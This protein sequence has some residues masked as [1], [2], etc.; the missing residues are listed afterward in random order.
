[1]YADWQTL[2]SSYHLTLSVVLF[3]FA[4]NKIYSRLGWRV[5]IN[6]IITFRSLFVLGKCDIS[7]LLYFSETPAVAMVTSYFY[8]AYSLFTRSCIQLLT[9]RCSVKS[10]FV[11]APF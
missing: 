3:M 5:Q 6:I 2:Y 4:W 1:M 10:V 7:S 11:P 8:V 9:D